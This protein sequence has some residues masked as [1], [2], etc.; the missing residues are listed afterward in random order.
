MLLVTNENSV[1]F[2]VLVTVTYFKNWF[3]VWLKDEKMLG[4]ALATIMQMT[5]S[6]TRWGWDLISYVDHCTST[7]STFAPQSRFFLMV[8]DVKFR[9]D[10]ITI[11]SI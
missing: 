9:S 7:I 11:W 6:L 3:E 5:K 2:S 1:Q 10:K 8:D 4:V